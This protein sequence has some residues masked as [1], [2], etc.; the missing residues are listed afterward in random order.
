MNEFLKTH[1]FREVKATD[2]PLNEASCVV[3]Q[4]ALMPATT[5][6]ET[7]INVFSEFRLNRSVFNHPADL[8]FGSPRE[9]SAIMCLQALTEDMD[10]MT[11]EELHESLT[12]IVNEVVAHHNRL[13]E[14]ERI[15][16]LY[17]DV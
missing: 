7:P 3:T 15:K 10:H 8:A 5:D 16:D 9:R 6:H 13:R 17:P 2:V 4:Y 11:C 1:L 14:D 12:D